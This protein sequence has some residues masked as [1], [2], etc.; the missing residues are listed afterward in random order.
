[1][2]GAAVFFNG[3]NPDRSNV[4]ALNLLSVPGVTLVFVPLDLILAI[5][6]IV[7]LL[8]LVMAL[9]LVWEDI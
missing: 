7:L 9:R 3:V 8:L 6:G 4:M 1:M 2:L 5:L